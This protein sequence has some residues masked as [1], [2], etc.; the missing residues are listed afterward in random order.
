MNIIVSRF[1]ETWLTSYTNE[2]GFKSSLTWCQSPCFFITTLNCF[3]I[4]EKIRAFTSLTT[5]STVFAV[6]LMQRRLSVWGC[7]NGVASGEP[8]FSWWSTS[9]RLLCK[10]EPAF[11]SKVPRDRVCPH[12]MSLPKDTGKWGCRALV[13]GVRHLTCILDHR[14]SC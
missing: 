2:S 8:Y 5:Y 14:K 10:N 6:A 11:S 1:L 4:L 9:L 7:P 12:S 13:V 3:H